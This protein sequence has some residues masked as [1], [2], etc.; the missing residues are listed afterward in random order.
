MFDTTYDLHQAS[1]TY[2]GA[3]P[4]MDKSFVKRSSRRYDPQ[5][6]STIRMLAYQSRMITL[7]K[8]ILASRQADGYLFTAT[9]RHL[10]GSSCTKTNYLVALA[11]LDNLVLSA[12]SSLNLNRRIEYLPGYCK[13]IKNQTLMFFG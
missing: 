5:R 13:G 6:S 4:D 2:K 7:P 9:P 11:S 8:S 12:G 3:I 10:A 1:F